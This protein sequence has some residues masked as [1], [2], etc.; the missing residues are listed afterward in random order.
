MSAGRP[1]RQMRAGETVM[2]GDEFKSW[3][4]RMDGPSCG[5]VK[6]IPVKYR[7]GLVLDASNCVNFRTRRP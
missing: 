2:A 5:E 3:L 6:W 4:I 1:W 7:L